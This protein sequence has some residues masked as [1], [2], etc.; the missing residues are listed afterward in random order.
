MSV[1]QAQKNALFLASRGCQLAERLHG[2][3]AV[4]D[5]TWLL[6]LPPDA[7]LF[8]FAFDFQFPIDVG[9]TGTVKGLL[10]MAQGAINLQFCIRMLVEQHWRFVLSDLQNSVE[11]V[12]Q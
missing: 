1:A 8:V 12:L 5:P 6:L 7:C 11:V 2:V 4:P 10:D 9:R 3:C